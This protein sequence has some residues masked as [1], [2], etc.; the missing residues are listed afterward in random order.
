MQKIARN[1]AVAVRE[2]T[3]SPERA[4]DNTNALRIQTVLTTDDVREGERGKK[5]NCLTRML[6]D[7]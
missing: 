7:W 5:A 1:S 3:L 6:V 2:F 4:F